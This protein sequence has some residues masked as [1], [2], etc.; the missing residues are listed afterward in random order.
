M[1]EA[2][3][4]A[5]LM[6]YDDAELFYREYY[7]ACA[8]PKKLEAFLAPLTVE[9]LRKRRLLCP[10]LRESPK[11]YRDAPYFN[12]KADIKIEKHKRYIPAEKHAHECFE[13]FYVLKGSCRH[14]LHGETAVLP[15]NTFVILAPYVG[16]SIAV[17]DDS[18][19]LNII[20]RSSTFD[21][22]LF[23][24]LRHN[25]KLSYFFT[26]NLHGR[27]FISSMTV[28]FDNDELTKLLMQMVDE[29]SRADEYTDKILHSMISLF[30]NKLSR[31][32]DEHGCTY[33]SS[34]KLPE[35]VLSILQYINDNYRELT[36][37]DLADRFGY[38]VAH[39]SRLIKD[40]TGSNFTEILRRIRLQRAEALLATT[41]FSIEKISEII[42]YENPVSF[43]KVFKKKHGVT[44]MQYRAIAA[45]QAAA[46]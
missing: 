20:I 15:E 34:K 11:L 44:P 24:I 36:L 1:D 22:Y 8:S 14:T 3:V 33:T 40:M 43:N 45:S 41:T 13:M 21:D 5:A 16:H 38:T 17:F 26:S 6:E 4:M 27:S 37:N 46:K 31:Y 39:C 19:I 28:T 7:E 12:S 2:A 18:I 10:H 42:G 32:C 30:F 25:N 35:N 9:G 29:Q 23:N